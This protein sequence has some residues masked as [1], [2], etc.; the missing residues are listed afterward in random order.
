MS[1]ESWFIIMWKSPNGSNLFHATKRSS[2]YPASLILRKSLWN[3]KI[4]NSRAFESRVHFLFNAWVFKERL[5]VLGNVVWIM[6]YSTG[7]N[8][9]PSHVLKPYNKSTSKY[10]HVFAKLKIYGLMSFQLHV[11]CMTISKSQDNRMRMTR[12]DPQ[13]ILIL[14]SWTSNILMLCSQSLQLNCCKSKKKNLH[15]L[16]RENIVICVQ[17]SYKFLCGRKLY[18]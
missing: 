13:V 11:K 10:P 7:K 1:M 2:N 9:C 4:W 3:Y 17:N 15:V 8:M 14:Q 5:S 6:Y 18:L 12:S 16:F